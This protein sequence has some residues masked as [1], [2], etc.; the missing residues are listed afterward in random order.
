MWLPA[1]SLL[2]P[3][4]LVSVWA[5]SRDV[6]LRAQ[7]DFQQRFHF[8]QANDGGEFAPPS[9]GVLMAPSLL[10]PEPLGPPATFT[11]A[12]VLVPPTAEHHRRDALD[13]MLTDREA[14]PEGVPSHPPSPTR[15]ELSPVPTLRSTRSA[16][17]ATEPL[18]PD[19]P[20]GRSVGTGRATW[21]EH[22]GR[23][24]SGERFDPDQLTAAHRTLRFG[25]RLMVVNL[26]NGRSVRV[27]INDRTPPDIKAVID[28]SRG[29][30]REIGLKDVGL[31]ALYEAE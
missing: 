19:R 25:T 30:A 1:A 4:G 14:A 6:D 18:P 8:D 13:R 15:A 26:R 7:V 16:L 9:A 3:V 27:R 23:T 11:N 5:V 17:A 28:L 22:P 20:V 31:V 10:S 12:S 21:Y 29:S 24:A 2:V